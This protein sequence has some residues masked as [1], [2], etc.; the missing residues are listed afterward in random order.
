MQIKNIY[1]VIELITLFFIKIY[2]FRLNMNI[3][4]HGNHHPSL[5]ILS[6]FLTVSENIKRIEILGS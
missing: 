6:K 3:I 5:Y 2:V 4:I 1:I